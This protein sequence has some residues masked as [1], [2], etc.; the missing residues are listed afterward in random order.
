MWVQPLGS[1][2]PH[3]GTKDAR[4]GTTAALLLPVMKTNAVF[5]GAA[6]PVVFACG[7]MAAGQAA[8]KKSNE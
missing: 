1:P 3:A 5:H 7:T 2:S 6:R 4:P 8:R